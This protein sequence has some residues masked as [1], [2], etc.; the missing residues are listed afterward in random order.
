[1]KVKVTLIAEDLNAGKKTKLAEGA[2]LYDGKRLLYKEKD[3][4]ARHEII[5]DHNGLTIKRNGDVI[6]NTFL[7][8]Q[9]QGTSSVISEYG[10]MEV[11]AIAEHISVNENMWT[12]TYRIESQG[13]VTLH[14]RLEWHIDKF[15]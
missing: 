10:T 3:T 8:Y 11:D 9:G 7:P 1:M 5:Q 2:A 12:V 13:D 6:S 4:A 15:V 14:Q